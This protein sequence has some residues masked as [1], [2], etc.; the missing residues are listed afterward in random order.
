[1]VKFTSD[2][3]PIKFEFAEQIGMGIQ[4]ALATSADTSK[5]EHN[6]LRKLFTTVENADTFK[7]DAFLTALSQFK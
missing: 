7:E 3:S 2:Y 1:M 6:K 5:E 4:A